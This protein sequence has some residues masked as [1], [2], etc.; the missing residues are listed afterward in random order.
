LHQRRPLGFFSPRWTALKLILLRDGDGLPSHRESPSSPL[1]VVIMGNNMPYRLPS[2]KSFADPQSDKISTHRGPAYYCDEICHDAYH[3][4]I[5]SFWPR[6]PVRLVPELDAAT[7]NPAEL[8]SSSSR[9]ADVIIGWIKPAA[10]RMD[11]YRGF[12]GSRPVRKTG[13]RLDLARSAPRP[14]RGKRIRNSPR[15][16]PPP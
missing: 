8:T 7:A 6:R 12:L 11:F 4:G 10:G 15:R 16:C 3:R 13:T 9:V 1:S 2:V 14:I 5:N